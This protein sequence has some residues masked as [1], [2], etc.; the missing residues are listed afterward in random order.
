MMCHLLCGRNGDVNIGQRN[1]HM[2]KWLTFSSKH[3]IYVANDH[4]AIVL[5]SMGLWRQP[6][7]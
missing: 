1:C 2:L 3:H 6:T 4:L 5:D 7:I